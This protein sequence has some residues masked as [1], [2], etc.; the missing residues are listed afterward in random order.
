MRG[1]AKKARL[2]TLWGV[3]ARPGVEPAVVAAALAL[4]VVATGMRG[5]DYPAQ[6]FRAAIYEADGFTIWNNAWYSGHFTPSYSLITPPLSAWFGPVAVTVVSSIASAYLF[7][8]LAHLSPGTLARWGAIVFAISTVANVLVGRTAFALGVALGLWSLDA[9]F[10]DRR[11]VAIAL[12]VLAGL[13]TPVASVFLGVITGA[14][15]LNDAVSGPGRFRPQITSSLFWAASLAPVA[16]FTLAFGSDGIFQFKPATLVLCI[17]G[18]VGLA[19]CTTN[20][21]VWFAAAAGLIGAIAF[22]S[23]E[24]PMGGNFQRFPMFFAGTSALLFATQNRRRLAIGL[25]VL[26][27]SWAVFPAAESSIDA[28]ADPSREEAY[29]AP[30]VNFINWHGDTNSRVEIPFTLNHWESHYV[31]TEF[32]LA[33][34]WERQADREVNP[35]FYAGASAAEYHDWLLDRAVRWVALPDVALDNGGKLEAEILAGE[36]DWLELAWENEHW[37]VWEVTDATT[38]L[39]EPGELVHLGYDN[40]LLRSAEVGT[41]TLRIRF[42]PYWTVEGPA[43]INATEDGLTEIHFLHPGEV[44]LSARLEIGDIGSTS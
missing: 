21:V 4:L 18:A 36:H 28:Y 39:S 5:A 12:A 9:W 24:N 23:I 10:R 44:K 1:I 2:G 11:G 42:M 8:R 13:A 43:S 25:A 40:I 22:F 3:D 33:R 17:V 14:I 30:L 26:F 20:P 29:F 27:A 35:L 38:I 32:S 15:A 41:A 19:R 37:T 31:A 6:Y 34:G 7:G 16:A